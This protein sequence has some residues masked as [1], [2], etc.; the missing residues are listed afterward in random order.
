MPHLDL[1]YRKVDWK[2]VAL[3]NY[4]HEFTFPIFSRKD[5]DCV[6]GEN[7]T[8]SST[9]IHVFP[10]FGWDGP[11]WPAIDSKAAM[12]AALVHDVLYRAM[13]VG[14][15]SAKYRRKSDREFRRILKQDEMLWIRRW[16]WW[17]IVRVFGGSKV[18]R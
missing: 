2:Y 17:V 11:S 5:F 4:D 1:K 18:K 14:L 9:G 16:A 7:Y 3:D 8:V 10:G 6:E 15:I 13:R 12:R